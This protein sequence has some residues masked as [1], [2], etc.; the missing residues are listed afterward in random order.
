MIKFDEKKKIFHLK[1]KSYSYVMCVGSAGYLQHLYYGK[2]IG[3]KDGSYLK[4]CVGNP[5]DAV[6]GDNYRDMRTND[7]WCEYSSYGRCDFHEPCVLIE[8]TDGAVMSLFRY[9]SHTISKG[10]PVVKGMPHIRSGDSTLCIALRDDFSD[11]EIR[12]YYIVSENSDVLVRYCEIVN[13][14]KNTVKLTKAFSFVLDLPDADYDLMRFEGNQTYER[15][16]EVSNIAHGI[17]RLQSLRG[18]SSHQINPFAI[19][20]KKNTDENIGEC[21]GIQLIYSGSW[22]ITVE[23][24][25][26]DT[27]RVQGGINDTAFSWILS[28]GECFVTPQVAL[29]YSS[30]GL[31]NLS[32]EYADFIRE[33]IMPSS[34]AFSQRPIVVN[35]WEATYFD[36]TYEK[37][38]AIID[39][40]SGLG[41]DTFVLDDGWFGARNWDDVS[42]G[43]WFI[44][45]SKLPDGL[46]PI[47]ERCKR[48]GMKFGIWFEPEMISEES[49]LYRAHPDWAL[50]KADNNPSRQRNQLVLDFANPNVVDCVFNAVSDVLSN[51]DISYVKWDMNRSLSEFFS[52]YL[53]AD[54][55]GEVAHR[56]VLGVYALA[57]RLTA[58]FPEVFFEGCASGGGRFDAGMLYYFP[59][60]WTS[61][62]TDGYE[63]TRIQW[64]TSFGYPVSSMSCHVSGCPNHQTERTTPLTTRGAIASLGATG[65][66]LDV[67]KLS[68]SEREEIK[69]QICDY[70]KIESLVLYG[71][72]HRL[73]NPC[74]EN[75]FAEMLVSKNKKRA[76]L[77]G[78][79]FRATPNGHFKEKYLKLC[80]L[81]ENKIY[82][83]EPLN[84]K[85]SGSVLK[86]FGVPLP[87]LSD[88]G[89]FIWYIDEIEE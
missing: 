54:R 58:A 71:D 30:Q 20:L 60:I 4:E 17:T 74:N 15:R 23:E 1:G 67:S 14:G 35:N 24:N 82:K 89:S 22:A 85:A 26:C 44:N 43:D 49:E 39:G 42:L 32:R 10:T 36:F 50:G 72:L 13:T 73:S 21:F 65:Y 34:R 3:E 79:Q 70:R 46:K 8:R 76:Y 25:N 57:A 2:A 88:Y 31:G 61:D 87:H 41:V 78:E 55:Q 69:K 16:P 81:D 68:E 62:N 11:A 7:M 86:S 12:L 28:G 40:A 51:N 33:R 75:Y 52:P 38:F 66:E 47:I 27:L 77:V 80:G 29:C 59:Q 45:K 9:L 6:C 83:I 5:Q 53:P 48:H 63:R 19:L 56:Y 64:G 84:V 37:L 18:A